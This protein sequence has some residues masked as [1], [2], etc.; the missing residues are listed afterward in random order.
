[1]AE[2]RFVVTKDAKTEVITYMEYEKLKGFNVKPK[3]NMDI[4]DMINV[5]EMV[6]INP[7][8]IEKLVSKK[9]K[10]T[11]ESIIKM[12]SVIYEDGDEG[13][14]P[15]QRALDELAKF[16]AQ[17]ENKYKEYMKE[18]EFKL[19]L[20][21]I[22]ILRREVLLRLQMNELYYYREDSKKAR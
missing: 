6:V 2:R 4:Y 7:S 1:M 18:K 9:C 16:K 3:K 12:L 14:E 15:L 21:K 11:L 10:R 20:K 22:E 19:L 17:V 5:N 8:L 13:D